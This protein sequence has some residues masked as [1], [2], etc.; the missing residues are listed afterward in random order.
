MTT[1]DEVSFAAGQDMGTRLSACMARLAAFRLLEG[2]RWWNHWR[3]RP[4]A[5]ALLACADELE[6]GADALRVP[7][8]VEPALAPQA[9]CLVQGVG[10]ADG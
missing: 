1:R 5:R 10:A 3:L 8:A 6:D 9:L 4:M 2:A 7:T